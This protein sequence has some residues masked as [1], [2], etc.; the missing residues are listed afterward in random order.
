MINKMNEDF[1]GL[2]DP[3]K[4]RVVAESVYPA[5]IHKPMSDEQLFKNGLP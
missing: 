4:D 3:L 5:M 1:L 2:P